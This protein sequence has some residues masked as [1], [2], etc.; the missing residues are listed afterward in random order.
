[1]SCSLAGSSVTLSSDTARLQKNMCRAP[2]GL[3]RPLCARMMS[4]TNQ[5]R[6]HCDQRV[7]AW[8]GGRRAAFPAPLTPRPISLAHAPFSLVTR[9]RPKVRH[10]VVR[11]AARCRFEEGL[12]LGPRMPPE[13]YGSTHK[14]NHMPLTVSPPTLRP[15]QSAEREREGGREDLLK[16]KIHYT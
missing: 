13:K 16:S 3:L 14:M 4:Q 5:I 1:M 6:D 8:G 9:E 11:Y 12:W 2:N 15:A 10:V 7:T